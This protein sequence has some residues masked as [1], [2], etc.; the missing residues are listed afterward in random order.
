[1]ICSAI[2]WFP[3]LFYEAQGRRRHGRSPVAGRREAEQEEVLI[4][5]G[6]AGWRMWWTRSSGQ[7]GVNRL[8]RR[9]RG[10]EGGHAAWG[11]TGGRTSGGRAS[12]RDAQGRASGVGSVSRAGRAGTRGWGRTWLGW[13]V[14]LLGLGDRSL[15]HHTWW[16]I[17]ASYIYI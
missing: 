8:G 3:Q 16:W 5:E 11:W 17:T 15:I 12:R 13:S 9:R 1:M 6:G 10:R 14:G 2:L 4:S 7:H